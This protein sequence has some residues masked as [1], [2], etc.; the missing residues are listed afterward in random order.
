[1]KLINKILG[2][3]ITS[4]ILIFIVF[5]NISGCSWNPKNSKET[6]T[7]ALER[8]RKNVEEGRGVSVKGLLGG[9][10][11]NYEFSSS[12]PLW[13]ATLDTL[14]FLPLAVV[15]YSGGIVVTDWYRNNNSDESIKISIRFTSNEVRSDSLKILVHKK[16]CIK[17]DN[18]IISEVNSKIKDELQVSIIKKAALL[19]KEK[20]K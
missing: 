5:Q 1:M 4:L 2:K 15:D 13:R 14:D 3:K 6:P 11:T 10:S 19:D 9:G 20:K 16:K 18:C 8:A 7:N 17:M 12:N